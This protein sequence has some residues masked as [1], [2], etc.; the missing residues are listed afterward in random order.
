MPT[1]KTIRETAAMGILPET[2]LR[3]RL[4]QGKLPGIYT[5]RTFRVN[6]EA[7]VELLNA[8]SLNNVSKQ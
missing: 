6:V 3:M 5:G 8:E 2:S 7:L 4:K 1:F